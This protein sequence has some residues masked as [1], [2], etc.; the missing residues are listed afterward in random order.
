LPLRLVAMLDGAA[1]RGLLRKIGGGYIFI[2]D[3]LREHLA[4]STPRTIGVR[5]PVR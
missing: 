2:H 4:A 5:P 3:E 1:E